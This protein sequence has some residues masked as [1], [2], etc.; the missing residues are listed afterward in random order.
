MNVRKTLFTGQKCF[1]GYSP[2]ATLYTDVYSV[3]ASAL[4]KLEME[5][6]DAEKFYTTKTRR[7]KV[8]QMIFNSHFG[9]Y[10]LSCW[11]KDEDSEW[12]KPHNILI[13]LGMA[14]TF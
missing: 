10:D 9:I 6:L 5:P 2:K 4:S 3:C 13:E 7:D 14:I 1:I 12:V 8:A 11:R